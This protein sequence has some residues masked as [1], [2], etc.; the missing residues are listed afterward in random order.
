[1]SYG[2]AKQLKASC[3]AKP[4]GLLHA[5]ILLTAVARQI[6]GA[7][8][9]SLWQCQATILRV[10]EGNVS[11]DVNYFGWLHPFP[12]RLLLWAEIDGVVYHPGNASPRLF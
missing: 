1:M 10:P 12:F 11:G 8:G 7:L 2:N 5:Y 6:G 3:T 4:A 9:V